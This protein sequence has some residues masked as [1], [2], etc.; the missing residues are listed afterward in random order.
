MQPIGLDLRV[1]GGKYIL[2]LCVEVGDMSMF[3]TDL[4]CDLMP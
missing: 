4:V 2:F 1:V 3:E